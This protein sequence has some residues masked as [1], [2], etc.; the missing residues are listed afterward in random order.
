MS[1]TQ[2]ERIG[3]RRGMSFHMTAV[4]SQTVSEDPF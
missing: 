4:R 3:F 1:S 2:P